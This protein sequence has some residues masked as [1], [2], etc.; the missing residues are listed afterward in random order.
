ML[1]LKN[2]IISFLLFLTIGCSKQE[3]PTEPRPFDLSV[4][5]DYLLL[6]YDDVIDPPSGSSGRWIYIIGGNITGT[7]YV[8]PNGDDNNPGTK[9]RP[10]KSV[11]Y[12]VSRLSPGDTLVILPSRSNRRPVIAGG[13]NLAH[14]INLSGKSYIWIENIELTHNDTLR[15]EGKFFRDGIYACDAPASN[16]VLKNIYIHHLD[17]MGIN[18]RDVDRLEIIGC[19][20]E[21]C[22]FGAIGGPEATQGGWRNVLIKKCTLSYSGHYYGPGDNPYDRPDGFG[23]EES[24]GPVLI[25]NTV[26]MY[27]KGDGIDSK[28]KN[29]TIKE[30]IVAN[31]SCDG[32]K[33]WGDNSKV[34]NTLIYGRGDRDTTTTP[35]GAIVI[36]QVEQPNS[37]F[38]II[39]C[40]IDDTL[41][42]INIMY[43]Q[44]GNYRSIPVNITLI[45]NIFSGRGPNCYIS[46]GEASTIIAKHNLFYFPKSSYILQ[47]GNNVY[48]STNVLSLGPGNIYGSPLYVKTA[49]GDIGD[50]HLKDGSPAIDA[51][52]PD[53]APNIDLDGK[54]RPLGSGFDMGCYERSLVTVVPYKKK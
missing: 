54:P 1:G 44:T 48:D 11:S 29:T 34:I 52:T 15:G 51:G 41:G 31:N 45:N 36:D 30:C 28:A 25:E 39:N 37:R 5:Y 33:I 18:I 16:I 13:N 21:Y 23:I 20:I 35:W 14:A 42:K 22:G 50:Y 32:V 40:T 7:F 26:V 8:S 4:Y 2:L 27:N 12:A 49:W 43:V 17:E 10:W 53:G 47:H 46:I 24:L 3:T 6:N 38:E 9:E 19:R